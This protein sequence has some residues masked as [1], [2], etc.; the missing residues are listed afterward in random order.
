MANFFG[1]CVKAGVEVTLVD[2]PGYGFSQVPKAVSRSWD[3]LLKAYLSRNSI[4]SLFFLMDS[5]RRIEAEERQFLASLDHANHQVYVV[6]TKADKLNKRDLAKQKAR[7]EE[8]LT[9]EGIRV[10]G[11]FQTSSL[12]RQGVAKI[13]E[14]IFV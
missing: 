4:R 11:V 1:V 6:M 12:T 9:E 5:R 14:L 7:L 10:A 3:G 2:L 8:A 13:Q